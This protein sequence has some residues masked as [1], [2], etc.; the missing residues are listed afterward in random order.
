MTIK[1]NYDKTDVFYI[2]SCKGKNENAKGYSSKFDF[3]LKKKTVF[4][5]WKMIKNNNPPGGTLTNLWFFSKL[6]YFLFW[7]YFLRV[8]SFTY[9]SMYSFS[10]I[11]RFWTRW[12]NLSKSI[13]QRILL[14]NGYFIS[15]INLYYCVD[16]IALT[17]RK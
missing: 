7:V 2:P 15:W 1:L 8:K 5:V 4:L 16:F 11:K 12:K 6:S 17:C 13:Y 14:I 3:F 9:S 10:Q